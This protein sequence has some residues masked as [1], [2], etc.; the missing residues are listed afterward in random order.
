M[1]ATL[2]L[3]GLIIGF[4]IAAPLGPIGVLCIRRTLADGRLPGLVSGLGAATADGIYG[5][6]AVLG[7]TAVAD[8]LLH[9]QT[10]LRAAGGA[11]LCLL[12]VRT[13]LA[14]PPQSAPK[15]S[16]NG[17]LAAYGSTLLLTLANP[18]GILAF[19][20]IFAG[21]GL[22]GTATSASAVAL[23][24]GVFSGSALWWWLLTTTVSWLRGRITRNLL[25]RVNR[26]AGVAITVL[27]LAMALAA[28]P[29]L[30][31]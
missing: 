22:A 21:L 12:G 30:T 16:T 26:G 18:L 28:V 7:I 9:Y 15:I 13:M 25:I 24:A 4:S 8:L 11:F 17:L 2:F 31:K 20:A 19:G 14:A 5:C 3:R 1:D 6:L 27:G 10:G 23:V 29:G